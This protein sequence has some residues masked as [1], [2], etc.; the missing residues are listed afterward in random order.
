MSPMAC[1][2]RT[3][4]SE[5]NLGRLPEE[6]LEFIADHVEHCG[7][8]EAALKELDGEPDAVVSSLRGLSELNARPAPTSAPMTLPTRLGSYE[9]L[10]ELGRGAM[11]IVYQARHLELRRVV[12]LKMLLGGEFAREENRARFRAEAE[13]VA[14]LQHPNIIQIFELGE[15]RANDLGTPCP[16]LTLEYVD[17]GNLGNRVAGNPQSPELA[18]RW[19]VILAHAVHYAHGQGIVHR[20]LKPSNVLLTADGRLKL[21]DFGVAKLVTGSGLATLGGQLVGTP[22]YMAPEQADGQGRLAGPVSDVYGLGGILYTMLTGRPPFQSPS[23][24]GTLEQVLTSEPISPRRLQPA[25]PRD[26]ETICLKCLQKEPRRRYAS[27]AQLAEDLERFLDG[28]AILARPTGLVDRGWKWARRRPA[29]A[30]LSAATLAV[31]V[32]SFVLIAWQWRRAEYEATAQAAAKVEAVRLGRKAIEGQTELALNHGLDLC[33]RGEVGHG[34][35][36][37]A[38]SLE[39]AEG[40]AVRGLD[41]ATRVN[42]ADW[43]GQ[44]SR[45][46]WTAR[47]SAPILDLAF[48]RDGRTLVSVGKDRHVRTWDTNSGQESGPPLDPA[49]LRETQWVSRVALNPRDGRMVVTP[50]DGDASF[51]DLERRTRTGPT[52]SH[53]PG[54]TIWGL[55]FNPEGRK[56]VTCC[57]DGA[58]RWWDTT[59]GRPI[60]EPL[61]HGDEA[62]YYTLALSPDGRTLVTGGKDLRAVRWDVATGRPIGKPLMHRSPVHMIA[63][64]RDGRRVVTGTRDGG[65]RIWD[66]VTEHFTDLPPQ[67]SSVTSLVNSPDGRTLVTGTAGG[68]LRI[69]DTTTLGPTGP[70]YK[71]SSALTGLAFHPDGHSLAIGQDDGTIRLWEVPRLRSLGA[72]LQL[73]SAV[74]GLAFSPD[75]QSL[76]TSSSTGSQRWDLNGNPLGPLMS[77]RRY[78]PGGKVLSVDGRRT[79]DIVDFVEAT[80]VSPDCKTLAVARWTGNERHVRGCAETWDLATGARL[81]QTAEQPLPLAGVV[82]RPD[83][84]QLLTWDAQPRSTLLWDVADLQSARPLIRSLDSPIRRAVFSPDGTT[85][86][87]ACQDGT[88]RLWDVAR[89]REIVPE[90][91]PDHGYPVTA[92]AF[93]PAGPRIVTGCQAGSLGLWDLA[94]GTLLRDIRGN[95]DEVTSLS[96]SPDGRSLLTASHDGTARFWDVESGQQLGPPLHHTDAVLSAIFHPDGRSVVTG[97]KDGM[98][99]R[100]LVPL[101]PVKGTADQVRLA[102][103]GQTGMEMDDQGAI[104]TTSAKQY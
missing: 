41:R 20:D 11:G 70:T 40:A 7:R 68:F 104:H 97:T 37:M 96:F 78:E 4:L 50:E 32:L 56:L 99:Q 62:G 26:L 42:L 81:H 83:S 22:E 73:D 54:H 102:V 43:A 49:G 46:R 87:L 27:A 71:L 19:L 36:W 5:F 93:D 92:V 94:K 25:V 89:D 14:R 1:P 72:P 86:L 84:T 103:E 88:A 91:R 66:T 82:Y 52:F 30:L 18:A 33:K 69:W 12:A 34:L 90:R 16:Y 101:P 45:P 31:T 2:S 80:A 44:L 61:W 100:W 28:R 17:G 35:L 79:Y 64:L 29:V 65:L 55:A 95:A 75:G 58:A 85:L 74:H 10:S 76:V 51:W 24:L 53:P 8:C 77:S 6:H 47:N 57:D 21:C 60:G 13:A 38:R 39:L 63:F 59:T 67:G 9:V 15:W 3:S 23:V 48:S 98:V